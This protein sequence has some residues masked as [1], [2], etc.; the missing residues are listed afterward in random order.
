[1]DNSFFFSMVTH[2]TCYI[3]NIVAP[4]N[5]MGLKCENREYMVHALEVRQSYSVLTH[6]ELPRLTYWGSLTPAG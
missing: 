5:S 3:Y 6:I 1:M 4:F 2:F